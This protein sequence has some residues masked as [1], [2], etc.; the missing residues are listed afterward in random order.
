LQTERPEEPILVGSIARAHGIKGEV[1]VDVWSDAPER[2]APGATVTAR[3][4]GG[5]ERAMTVQA[6]RPFGER[7]LITF[8]GVGTRTEAEALRGADL[9]IPR[10]EA[11]ALPEGTHYRFE[12]LGLRV[13]TR[14][15]SELGTIA[16][17][18]S[19]GSNDVIV[20]RGPRGETLL[21][22]LASVVL[23]VDLER[24]EM[25]VEVPPGL[26]E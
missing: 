2:F 4:V 22:S 1:V 23:S 5:G 13:V 25:V 21:P 24:G 26:N 15:G 11:A 9:T 12:L 6:M 18:F 20:V 14:E 16:D 17:I 7:L 10:G 3:L 19:T 8:E